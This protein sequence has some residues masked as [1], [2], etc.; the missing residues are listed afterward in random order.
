V[1]EGSAEPRSIARTCYTP[2]GQRVVIERDCDVWVVVC[3]DHDRVRH[4][5]LDVALTEAVGS[6][7]HGHWDGIKPGRWVELVAKFM[8]ESWPR[9]K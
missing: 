5:H 4:P 2:A 1:L 6:D 7:V 8:V 3:D 9:R